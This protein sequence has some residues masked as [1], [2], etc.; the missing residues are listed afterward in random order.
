MLLLSCSLA[1]IL[2]VFIILKKFWQPY[3]RKS[4]KLEYKMLPSID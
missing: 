1:E 3:M 2:K 4:I